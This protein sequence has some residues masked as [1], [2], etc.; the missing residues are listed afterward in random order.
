M[1]PFAVVFGLSV[2]RARVFVAGL[3]VAS[4]SLSGHTLLQSGS[5]AVLHVINDALHGLAG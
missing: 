5:L 2:T 3:L 4:L 1:T